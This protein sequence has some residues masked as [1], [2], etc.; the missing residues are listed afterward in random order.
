MTHW[1]QQ[2]FYLPSTIPLLADQTTQINGT[3]EMIR[4]KESARLYNVRF[5]YTTSRRMTGVDNEKGTS[6]MNGDLVELVY[7]IP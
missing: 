7:Q 3:I 4:S 2:V 5:L 6:L 1:G